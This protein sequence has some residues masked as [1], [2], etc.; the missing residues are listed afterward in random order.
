MLWENRVLQPRPF[1]K[2][3]RRRRY[4]DFA[5]PNTVFSEKQ[6][7][8]VNCLVTR[9]LKN[10]DMGLRFDDQW[11]FFLKLGRLAFFKTRS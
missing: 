1:S 9:S 8:L 2:L 6:H 3:Y 10:A 5:D 7:G 11:S 4:L